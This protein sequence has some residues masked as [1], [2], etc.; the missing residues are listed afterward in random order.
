M[1]LLTKWLIA[2]N[3]N[4]C[5]GLLMAALGYFAPIKGIITVMVAAII[6]D[7][8]TGVWAALVQKKG[9]KS[10][11][12]WRTGYKL[13]F[14]IIIVSLFYAMDKEIGYIDMHRIIAWII[15]G[16][17]M[18]SILENAAKISDHKIFRILKTY[19][20]GKLKDT[21]GEAVK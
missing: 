5:S 2:H 21:T 19:M 13:G 11:K 3:Y 17:E 18:W 16:F 20:E 14:A 4:F 12:L 15:T 10:Q 1:R 8:V 9:I 6:I 7:L